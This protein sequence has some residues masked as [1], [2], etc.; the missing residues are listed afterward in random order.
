MYRGPEFV[1]WLLKT[2]DLKWSPCEPAQP[3]ASALHIPVGG[4]KL[5]GRSLSPDGGGAGLMEAV[6]KTVEERFKIPLAST[7]AKRLITQDGEVVGLIATS[8]RRHQH[9]GAEGSDPTAGGF[10]WNAE[11]VQH[12]RKGPS[13]STCP[14]DD[15]GDGI[16]MGHAVAPTGT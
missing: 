1:T 13:Y 12:Y 10:S 5:G 4:G 8:W 6:V 16:L 14:L 7:P 2:V 3:W 9:Q 15:T 11:M